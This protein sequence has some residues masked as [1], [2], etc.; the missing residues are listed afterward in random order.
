MTTVQPMYRMPVAF[1][2]SAGPRRGPDGK[3][4]NAA[5]SVRTLACDLSWRSERTAVAELLPRGFELRGEPIVSVQIGY[6]TDIEW[7]AGRGYNTLGVYIPATYCGE[8]RTDG[9]FNAVLWENLT[10]PI[11]TGRD[12]LGIPKIYAEI[13]PLV[14]TSPTSYTARSHWLGF[15]F[16]RFD[17]VLG[18]RLD[19]SESTEAYPILCYKYV[20]RTGSWGEADCEYV[21]AI[22]ADD[23]SRSVVE[24]WSITGS[25]S[26]G[27][28]AW[29]DM[30]TQYHI[31]N[32]LAALPVVEWLGGRMVSSVGGKDLSDAYR[33][34]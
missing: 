24:S 13:G 1:G 11:L 31:V 33:V 4:F 6:H 28:A 18:R 8:Q 2:P 16:L 19:P 21:T 34:E 14:V 26:F 22:P 29:R 12:E 23:P 30:P 7:L 15:E 9:M 32:R 27:D 5:E 17:V 20:P 3:R 10:D 25:V